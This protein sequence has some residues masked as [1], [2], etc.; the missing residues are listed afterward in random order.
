MSLIGL[1]SELLI[2]IIVLSN[3]SKSLRCSCTFFR[4]L[5]QTNKD[6][7]LLCAR[8][9]CN[10]FM[11]A[12]GRG[13]YNR[14]LNYDFL[15]DLS[16]TSLPT[17]LD[18]LMSSSS[19][20]LG[21][22]ADML[23]LWACAKSSCSTDR[24]WIILERCILTRRGQHEEEAASRTTSTTALLLGSALKI[25]AQ[26]GRTSIMELMIEGGADLY[27]YGT[28]VLSN[29]VDSGDADAVQLVLDNLPIA[30]LRGACSNALVVAA[31]NGHLE[32]AQLLVS[33]GADVRADD[34]EALC[35]AALQGHLD[36]VSLLLE[37]G[38]DVHDQCALRTI[39]RCATRHRGGTR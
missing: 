25:A 4:N 18:S 19:S 21:D 31:K 34:G 38:S 16:T 26:Y 24:A 36:V 9:V 35:S 10:H 23:W 30:A 12:Q 27:T 13:G 15:N 7:P 29:A 20:L 3:G 8:I 1:P 2:E 14:A 28:W 32:F 17:F 37:S 33:S 6:D 39:N 5:Y 11:T 22:A